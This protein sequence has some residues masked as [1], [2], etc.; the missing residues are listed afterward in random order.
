VRRD[1]LEIGLEREYALYAW[2]A[3]TLA[4]LLASE[5]LLAMF[6]AHIASDEDRHRR[7]QRMQAEG[8]RIAP[9]YSHCLVEIASPPYPRDAWPELLAGFAC[10]EAWLARAAEV[11]EAQWGAGRIVC[12]AEYSV[13]TDRFV[14]WGGALVTTFADL[15]LDPADA[16]WL[17]GSPDDV[18]ACL[19]GSAPELSYAGF[20]STNAT[21]HPPMP[22]PEDRDLAAD[23]EPLADY[24]W[25]V[26][27][28]ARQIEVASPQRHALLREGRIPVAPDP[29]L[30]IR[31]ALIRWGEP[32][33]AALLDALAPLAPGE[34][35]ARFR[36]LFGQPPSSSFTA[37]GFHAYSCRPRVI[38]NTMLF[39][40]RCFH[41]GLPLASLAPLLDAAARLTE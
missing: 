35:A 7:W 1:Q 41:S 15:L 36:A 26:L 29:E 25:R 4:Y 31:D 13:R 17:I 32:Q 24:F 27:H 18:P 6:H 40:L 14:S 20:T 10:L 34:G 2:T 8:W 21:V 19:I 30:S 12:T 39:E 28:A 22:G 38:A 11:L 9:E 5:R 16:N 37:A 33:T 23:A 3:G